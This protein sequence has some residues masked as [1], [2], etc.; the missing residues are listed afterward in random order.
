[1]SELMRGF[2]IKDASSVFLSELKP[3]GTKE[4]VC[5][6]DYAN[7]FNLS[8]TSETIFATGKGKNMIGFDGIPEG[9]VEFEAEVVTAELLAAKLGNAIVDAN[10]EI[11]KREVLTV[12]SDAATITGTPIGDA[13]TVYELHEGS[14]VEHKVLVEDAVLSDKELQLSGLEDGTQIAVYYLEEKADAKKIKLGVGGTKK[15]YEIHAKVMGKNT[16]GE[17][18]FL[19]I[20]IANASAELNVELN[21]EASSP[22]AVTTTFQLLAD[23]N[24][25]FGEI[26]FL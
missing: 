4:V 24:G 5:Y 6:F 26:V 25:E 22:T 18:V 20:M 19:E 10:R 1:M 12:N 9:T 7:T 15:Q 3:D 23:D 8:I 11:M 13:V 21:L 17:D 2:A 16:V 14:T